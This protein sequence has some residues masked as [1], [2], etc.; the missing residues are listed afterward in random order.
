MPQDFQDALQTPR[1]AVPCDEAAAAPSPILYNT[2]QPGAD[3]P[4]ALGQHVG[5]AQAVAALVVGVG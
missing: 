2:I 4:Y 3:N 1:H 5:L